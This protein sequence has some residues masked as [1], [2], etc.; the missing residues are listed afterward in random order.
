MNRLDLIHK[1]L[2]SN[3]KF[4]LEKT[5]SIYI[6]YKSADLL[7][8]INKDLAD[9]KIYPLNKDN[10]KDIYEMRR[11]LENQISDMMGV[12]GALID[13]YLEKDEVEIKEDNT[14]VV[15]GFDDNIEVLDKI[16]PLP[17]CKHNKERDLVI[18]VWGRKRRK[19]L[20]HKVDH[21]FNAAVL[22]GKKAG[23][24]WTKDGRSEEI[25]NSVMKC[26]IFNDFLETMI[27]T[28]E[29]KDAS[30]IGLNC[31]AG[32]HRSVTLAVVLK[33]YYYPKAVLHFLEIK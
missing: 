22:Y 21:N 18:H 24:D 27:S 10:V 30:K 26:P 11:K 4:I 32:R 29:S 2:T 14:E 16:R 5:T 31:R 33:Q 25:R 19:F 6:E 1:H 3:C 13:W 20:P 23:I 12:M 9:F 17:I 15:D 7:L 8:H 28:I